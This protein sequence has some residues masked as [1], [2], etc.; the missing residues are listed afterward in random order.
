MAA[1]QNLDENELVRACKREDGRAQKAVYERYSPLML[2]LC[3]RYVRSLDEAKDVLQDGFVKVFTRIGDYE[4]KGSF[5]GWMRRI[6][7]NTAL[8][9]LRKKNV[10]SFAEDATELEIQD[11][12]EVNAISKISADEI[13]RL[14]CSL[15]VGYRTVFNLYAIEGYSHDEVAEM[16]NI[17]SVTS[18]S[19]FSRARTI[20]RDKMNALYGSDLKVHEK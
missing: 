1:K 18:R 7:V 16:M 13:H 9:S 6:F 17:S 19:Q 2:S 3:A 12:F 15:P 10:L 11:T 4:G 14:I 5:E 8:E 20:L